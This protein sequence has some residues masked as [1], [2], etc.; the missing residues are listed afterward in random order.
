MDIKKLPVNELKALL[1]DMFLE[2]ERIEA[3]IKSLKDVISHKMEE[4]KEKK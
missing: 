1:C 3:N 4:E 2:K